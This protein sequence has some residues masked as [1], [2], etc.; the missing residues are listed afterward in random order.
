MLVGMSMI[1]SMSVVVRVVVVVR[2]LTRTWDV[3]IRW[4]MKGYFHGLISVLT[5]HVCS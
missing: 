3:G 4:S 2:V 5:C 1:A